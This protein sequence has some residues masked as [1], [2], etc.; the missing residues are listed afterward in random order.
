MGCFFYYYYYYL[1]IDDINCVSMRM[2]CWLCNTIHPQRYQVV[3]MHAEQYPRTPRG[4]SSFF[5]GLGKAQLPLNFQTPSTESGSTQ[6]SP[7]YPPPSRI[8]P[9]QREYLFT[10]RGDALSRKSP[11]VASKGDIAEGLRFECIHVPYSSASFF[12]FFFFAP[13]L[14][15]GELGSHGRLGLERSSR[16]I[17]VCSV[18][19]FGP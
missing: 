18:S 7:A 11:T 17:C 12:F 10:A 19:E 6:T 2:P 15:R 9:K 14:I 13:F 4:P 16:A 3:K 8:P 5:A 1:F